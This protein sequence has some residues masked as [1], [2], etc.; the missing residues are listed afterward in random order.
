[1]AAYTSERL[2]RV[3][4]AFLKHPQPEKEPTIEDRFG[5]PSI[6]DLRP[7]ARNGN[8]RP[9]V[10][11]TDDDDTDDWDPSDDLSARKRKPTSTVTSHGSPR[12]KRNKTTK[13]SGALQREL[14]DIA[15]IHSQTPDSLSSVPN[16]YNFRPR[17][18][19]PV[20]SERAIDN[21]A[22]SAHASPSQPSSSQNCLGCLELGL[23]CSLEQDPL[24]YPCITCRDDSIDCVLHP[25]PTWKRPCEQCKGRH[26]SI[27]CSYNSSDYDHS[28][29][30]QFCHDRGF[31]CVAGP[32]IYQPSIMHTDGHDTEAFLSREGTTAPSKSE[33]TD[34]I[35]FSSYLDVYG[36]TDL[37]P[38]YQPVITNEPA[39]VDLPGFT[40]SFQTVTESGRATPVQLGEYGPWAPVNNDTANLAGPVPQSGPVGLGQIELGLG[41][42]N[43]SLFPGQ[44]LAPTMAFPKYPK[45]DIEDGPKP[46]VRRTEL[47]HPLKINHDPSPGGEPCHWC[48]NFAYGIS[49]LGVRYPT[50]IENKP[51][52]W[53]EIDDGHTC[54][55]REPSRMCV[56]CTFKRV[57][58]LYCSHGS[59]VPLE[60]TDALDV[61]AAYADLNKATMALHPDY[62]KEDDDFKEA[63]QTWCSL[64]RAPAS[65]RCDDSH[66]L[67]SEDTFSTIP[68]DPGCGLHLCDYCADLTAQY[69]GNL[70][71][72]VVHGLKDF[73]NGT[74]F[75]ADVEYILMDSENNVL[76]QQ[77]CEQIRD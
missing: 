66:P 33:A 20:S 68:T 41:N 54:E 10:I 40:N 32:A 21:S 42:N 38:A 15:L 63:P 29:P 5:C 36:D 65:W 61:D 72:V 58:I 60:N 76:W 57:A 31:E 55:G 51:G 47:P 56:Q 46:T 59:I 77:I 24:S 67:A 45:F 50:V 12:P 44:I 48:D 69:H 52:E 25:A 2:K 73:D 70:E 14:D 39:P 19:R 49:G 11:C 75:R 53:T 4:D 23:D 43:T 37:T 6:Y 71:A 35:S 27:F 18:G 13:A 7:R 9:A 16:G 22:I 1:M 8:S 64:C 30:C 17:P 62:R 3:V 28:K 74:G 34:G 26:Q